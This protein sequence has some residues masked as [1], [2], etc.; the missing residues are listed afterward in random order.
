MVQLS[1]RTGRKGFRARKVQRIIH[2]EPADRG[3]MAVQFPVQQYFSEICGMLISEY[4]GRTDFIA[5]EKNE[6]YHE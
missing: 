6:V 4:R 5:K 3:N 1:V 2:K